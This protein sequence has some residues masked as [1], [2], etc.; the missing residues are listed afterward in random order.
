MVSQLWLLLLYSCNQVEYITFNTNL[1]SS[2]KKSN[3]IPPEIWIYFLLML[4][5][6]L[7]SEYP[8]DFSI[9]FFLHY[10]PNFSFSTK[11]DRYTHKSLN[12]VAFIFLVYSFLLMRSHLR[13][14]YY[15]FSFS[16][17]GAMH[18]VVMFPDG[19]LTYLFCWLMILNSTQAHH[20]K[21]NFL[22]S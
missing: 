22:L 14:F 20:C 19:N 7:L 12:V 13:H 8:E 11:F 6:L 5:W 15:L 10:C 21:I 18:N 9:Q 16:K 2:K 3:F 4:S 17:S 1:N